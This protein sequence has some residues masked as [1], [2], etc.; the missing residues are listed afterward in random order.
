MQDL[1]GHATMGRFTVEFLISNHRDV[2]A[3]EL[4]NIPPDQVRRATLRGLWIPARLTSCCRQPL[5][6]NS[7]YPRA[8]GWRCAMPMAGALRAMS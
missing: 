4:G 8:P 1:Q 7:A 5:S 6:S 3:A 2:I